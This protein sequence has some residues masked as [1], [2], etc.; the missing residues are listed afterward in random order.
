MDNI[1]T[2]IVVIVIMLIVPL[3]AT[4]ICN[5]WEAIK[6]RREIKWLNEEMDRIESLIAPGKGD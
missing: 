1:T 3:I 2:V 6:T 4:T 5:V